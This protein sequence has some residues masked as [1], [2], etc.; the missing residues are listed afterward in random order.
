MPFDI[1]VEDD[2]MCGACLGTPPL[3]DWAA[4]ALAYDKIS[5][6]AILR[7]KHAGALENAPHFARLLVR[8]LQE[9]D[10]QPEICIAVPL[11]A[12]RLFQRGFNQSAEIAR[13]LAP[14]I[15]A[16]ALPLALSRHRNT[17]SQ[18]G[19]TRRQRWHNVSGAF[20]LDP[21]YKEALKDKHI[22]L[23]DDVMTTGAT[24]EACCKALKKA[25]PA[26]IGVVTLA[27]VLPG[28]EQ[29]ENVSLSHGLFTSL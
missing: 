3:Y 5:K 6:A 26:S 16:E 22:I 23:V 12:R 9:K 28:P 13:H 25:K 18:A 20:K 1:V 2:P 29:G 7:L 11:H 27:R 8:L 14:L 10:A 24:I 21:K 15:G 4:S 19:L 17:P